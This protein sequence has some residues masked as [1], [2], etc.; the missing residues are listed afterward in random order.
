MIRFHLKYIE[1]PPPGNHMKIIGLGSCTKIFVSVLQSNKK[2]IHTKEC[3]IFLSLFHLLQMF[4]SSPISYTISWHL[5]YENNNNAHLPR[6]FYYNIY[7]SC[8]TINIL[9]ILNFFDTREMLFFYCRHTHIVFS[10]SYERT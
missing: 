5:F 4:L 10:S 1:E 7:N 9:Y 6:N 3:F 2:Y 8:I